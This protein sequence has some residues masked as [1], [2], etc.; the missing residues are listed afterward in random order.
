MLHVVY[1]GE[2]RVLNAETTVADFLALLKLD[3]RRCA[4]EINLRLVPRQQ[5][6]EV[7]LADGDRVE[8]VTLVGG[9]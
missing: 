7:K 5:H 6:A 9:G 8:V 2:P 3:P 4:V 1:N